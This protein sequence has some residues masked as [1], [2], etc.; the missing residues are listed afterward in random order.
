MLLYTAQCVNMCTFRKCLSEGICT[1]LEECEGGLEDK[2]LFEIID[3]ESDI[4]ES[5]IDESDEESQFSDIDTDNHF[6][7]EDDNDHS[8]CTKYRR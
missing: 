7:D 8:T 6:I 3:E 2:E 1:T 5:N 4:D